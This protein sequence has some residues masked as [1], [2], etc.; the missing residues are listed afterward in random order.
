MKMMENMDIIFSHN[1]LRDALDEPNY[2]FNLSNPTTWV[3]HPDA[4]EQVI[5][6][7]HNKLI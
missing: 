3:A 5:T 6:S 1:Q 2:S 7:E 4:I